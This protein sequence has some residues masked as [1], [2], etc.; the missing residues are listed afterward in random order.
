MANTSED[1]RLS[2]TWPCWSSF[3]LVIL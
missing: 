1:D 3:H 2:C